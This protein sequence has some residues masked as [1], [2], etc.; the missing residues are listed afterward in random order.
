VPIPIPAPIF[1]VIYIAYSSF[2]LDKGVGNV[3]HEA[4][5]GGALTGFLLAGL[6]S[7]YHFAPLLER[8]QRLLP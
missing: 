4:H 7:P 8:I 3:A 6:L 5:I 1:A 2:L